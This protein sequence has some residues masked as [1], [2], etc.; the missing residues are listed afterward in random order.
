MR[1]YIVAGLAAGLMTGALIA[2]APPASAGCQP[3]GF[4]QQLCDGPI[5][6]DGTWQ[7]CE[8][9]QSVWDPQRTQSTCYPLG[10]SHWLPPFQPPGH[11]DP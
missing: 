4:N 1:Q 6:P 2:S 9:A 3:W 11:I 8:V 5:Q 7:R 10:D